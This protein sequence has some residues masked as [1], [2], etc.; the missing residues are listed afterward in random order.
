MSTYRD[1]HLELLDELNGRLDR[2]RAGGGAKSMERHVSRGKLPVRERVERLCIGSPFLELSPL[3]AEELYDGT[4][5]APA[6]SPGW[7]SSTAAAA[8]WWPTTPP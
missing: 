5:P 4:R 6:W 7:R 1:A 2:A 3:A 8:W